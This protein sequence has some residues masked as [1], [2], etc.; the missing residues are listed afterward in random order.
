M[1][2]YSS[3]SEFNDPRMGHESLVKTLN[4]LKLTTQ[5]KLTRLRKDLGHLKIA[6]DCDPPRGHSSIVTENDTPM[7]N[8]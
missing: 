3:E 4:T 8:A 1:N 7:G 2:H 6:R 5:D